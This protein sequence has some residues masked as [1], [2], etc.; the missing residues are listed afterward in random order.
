M[1]YID[2]CLDEF[3]RLADKLTTTTIHQDHT[4]RTMRFCKKG[5]IDAGMNRGNADEM[6]ARSNIMVSVYM[7]D[8]QIARLEEIAYNIG[9]SLYTVMSSE[10]YSDSSIALMGNQIQIEIT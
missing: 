6:V 8:E 3:E 10:G 4:L 1:D 2:K 5:L 7:S 9:Y